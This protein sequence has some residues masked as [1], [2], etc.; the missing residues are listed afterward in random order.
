MLIMLP[1]APT[2]NQLWQ[3]WVFRRSAP[4]L[5]GLVSRL[6]ARVPLRQACH[7]PTTHQVCMA[8]IFY[9]CSYSAYQAG[10]PLVLH[11]P[12]CV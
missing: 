7:P 12:L 9:F 3:A 10:T 2:V 5:L 4:M 8:P 11:L 6:L 1:Q